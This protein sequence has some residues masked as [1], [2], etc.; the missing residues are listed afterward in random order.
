M[1]NE[2]CIKSILL[3]L[4]D[5]LV[6]NHRGKII[7]I[8][9]RNIYPNFEHL[10]NLQEFNYAIVYLVENGFITKTNPEHKNR[11]ADAGKINGITPAGY[12]LLSLMKDDTLWGKLKKKL[13][14][15]KIF[16]LL[17]AGINAAQ[18]LQNFL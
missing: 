1:L 18:L 8:H 14:L 12:Q 17:S 2:N 15:E 9:A 3:Y 11:S 13:T 5:N 4:Q 7:G 10:F 6:P 16:D